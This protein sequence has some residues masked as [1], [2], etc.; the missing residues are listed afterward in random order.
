MK[1]SHLALQKNIFQQIMIFFAVKLS[2]IY[3][4]MDE[5]LLNN[6]HLII[7]VEQFNI[8]YKMEIIQKALIHL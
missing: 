1:N 5:R 2:P 7:Y 3:K 8:N 6:F 4:C